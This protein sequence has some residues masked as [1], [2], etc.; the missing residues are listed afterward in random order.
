MA[1][2]GCPGFW[3]PDP[4]MWTVFVLTAVLVFVD[5]VSV[6]TVGNSD[7]AGVSEV[8]V[9]VPVVI[10]SESVGSRMATR[11][12]VTRA[13]RKLDELC[14]VRDIDNLELR[15]AIEELDKRLETLDNAQSVVE[16]ELTVE[17][18]DKRLETL[19]NAQS[20]VELELTVEQLE[21][22]VIVASEFRDKARVPRMRATKMMAARLPARA[23]SEQDSVSVVSAAVE[24][25]LP[26]KVGVA[27][28][29]WGC[30]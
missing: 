21:E 22:D 15:D 25:Q 6:G 23:P 7:L 29:W 2:G 12:W 8:R 18:L 19:D 20:V 28:I 1:H 5:V 13:S 30:Y 14:N 11:G 16:L 27:Y 4:G 26:K 24:A 17:Q 10:M 9:C 3:C